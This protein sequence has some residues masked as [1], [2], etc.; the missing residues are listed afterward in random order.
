MPYT[1]SMTAL[2]LALAAILGGI[3]GWLLR[4]PRRGT[5]TVQAAA[6]VGSTAELDKLRHR[7][8]NLEPAVAER[9]KLKVQLG[10]LEADLKAAKAVSVPAPVAAFAGVAQADHD[11]IVGERD[12]HAGR[13]A[14]LEAALAACKARPMGIAHDD[15]QAIVAER[16]HLHALVGKHEAHISTLTSE[17]DAARPVN[18]DNLQLIVGIGPVNEKILNESGVFTFEQ[19][20]SA[21]VKGLQ[22]I[23]PDLQDARIEKE[24]WVGQ[25]SK[26]AAAKRDGI[27]PASISRDDQVK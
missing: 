27:N 14:E 21:G 16:D 22:D 25:A 23:M 15:H 11:V 24:D 17:L 7:V 26:F 9:D 3:I 2:W 19:M 20:V 5:N 18:P 4:R 12:A 13:I 10:L 8:A 1:L 6:A